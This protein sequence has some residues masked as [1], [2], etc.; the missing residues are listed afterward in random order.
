MKRPGIVIGL[1]LAVAASAPAPAKDLIA[2][3]PVATATPATAVPVKRT[4]AKPP[5]VASTAATAQPGEDQ[6]GAATSRKAQT[7]AGAAAVP[8]SYAAIPEADRLAVQAD[9]ALLDNFDATMP[10]D[11]DALTL[12]AIRAFQQRHGGRDTGM[13]SNDERA[14]LAAAAKAP[15]EALGWRVIDDAATGARLGVPTK[16]VPQSSA[17]RTGSRWTS[18]QGQVQVE[19]MRLHEASLT[20][21]FDDQRKAARHRSVDYSELKPDSF[22]IFGMQGLKEYIV[23][24]Q[25]SG[26]ELRG[27][28]VLYDQATEGTMAPIAL[29]MADTFQGFPDP[30]AAPPPGIKRGV[31]YAT[32]VVVSSRG[33]LIAPAS[34]T[35]DCRSI[36]IA[37]LGHAER[38][39]EDRTDDLALLRLNG[40]QSLVPA[41]LAGDASATNALTLVGVADPLAQGGEAA[42]S[43]APAQLTAQGVDPAPKLG[44]AGAAAVDGQGRFAGMV[45]LTAPAVAGEGAVSQATLV[46]AAAVRTFLQAQGIAPATNT[47]AID[48]SVVRVICVR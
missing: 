15:K 24:V 12:A 32:A 2:P 35:D 44:F 22:V 18:A 3:K 20:A 25:A 4:P 23:R 40:A 10:K 16:V 30:N 47:A 46:P 31:E 48:Q 5:Q 41:A 42:V 9:L 17:L 28:T 39:A 45:D 34:A 19:T 13:L 29:A 8:A 7:P 37:G 43:H 38:V 11:R 1:L 6:P 14:A 33:H 26:N 36:T 21:L 27:I